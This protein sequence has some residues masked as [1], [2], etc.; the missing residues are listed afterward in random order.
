MS[1]NKTLSFT[2]IAL[3]IAGCSS[4]SEAGDGTNGTPSGAAGADGTNVDTTPATPDSGGGGTGATGASSS[5]AATG[6]TLEGVGGS[7]AADGIGGSAAQPAGT[8]GDVL[9]LTG[10]AAGATSCADISS[11]TTRIEEQAVPPILEFQIDVTGSMDDAAYPNDPQN[12]AT[13][14]EEMQRVLPT[15]FAS[16]PADWAVGVSY[17]AKPGDCYEPEQA[18]PIAPMTPDHLADINVSVE[19]QQTGGYTP[20]LVA[21]QFALAQVANWQPPA[22]PPDYSQSPR[23]V[24]LI[25]DGIPTVTRD[26]CTVQNPIVQEEYDYLV[27]T[28]RTQGQEAGVQTFVVGVLGSE[29]PQGATYDPLYMLSHVALAGGTPQPADCQPVSGT[30]SEPT[31]DRQDSNELLTRGTYCHF[32]M[33]ADPD[34][35]TGLLNALASIV[36]QVETVVPMSC[37][38]EVPAV[39]AGYFIDPTQISVKYLSGT[40]TTT[41]LTKSEDGSCATGDWFVAAQDAMGIPTQIELCPAM[42]ETAGADVGAEISLSFGCVLPQ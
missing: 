25:T 38:Y 17:F 7:G 6:G 26:G 31:G 16:L 18:V 34:F 3:I 11:Q 21:W 13:K 15:A 10:G 33:T 36:E 14:W 2:G 19:D 27:E 4:S 8:G 41:T 37:S 28:V 30:V 40:G 42:C 39:P 9:L 32:D 1:I 23:Y 20:T 5:T 29:S 35:A 12:G 24:V 22:P